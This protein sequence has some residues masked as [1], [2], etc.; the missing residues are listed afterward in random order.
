[1]GDPRRLKKKYK[2]PSHPFQ[3]QRIEEELRYLGEYGLRNKRE[4]WK[5]RT[6]LGN[7]RRTARKIR[8]LPPERQKKELRVLMDKL[9]RLGIIQKN[10]EFEDL[11]LMTID[12]ILN[13]RLQT[14]VFK[15]G[16]ANS[17]YQARQFITHR[18]IEVN[19]KRIDSP[20]Y[21]LKKDEEDTLKF[22]NSSS[23]YG[24]EEQPVS[25]Q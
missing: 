17:I 19:G 4:F 18:H 21:I 23:F 8:T 11:L 10:A 12:D 1:M 9:I 6:Q 5:H 13:R 25:E 7:Y 14:L 16:L 15:K 22:V 2:K 3:K 24:R 20:S